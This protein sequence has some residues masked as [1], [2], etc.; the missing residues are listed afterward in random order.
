MVGV[1]CEIHKTINLPSSFDRSSIFLLPKNFTSF[2]F[3]FLYPEISYR[4]FFF[5][6]SMFT[7]SRSSGGGR[8]YKA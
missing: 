8:C 4:F 6:L 1:E 5:R 2:F 7:S 3:F